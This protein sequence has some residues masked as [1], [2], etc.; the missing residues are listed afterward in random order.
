MLDSPG[1]TEI[2]PG[3][4]SFSALELTAATEWL[5][6]DSSQLTEAHALWG[7]SRWRRN[8]SCVDELNRKE[9][10]PRLK[11]RVELAG[12]NVNIIF[13]TWHIILSN[14]TWQTQ[15]YNS[16][17]IHTD[18]VT[19]WPG[20]SFTVPRCP[21]GCRSCCRWAVKSPVQTANNQFIYSWNKS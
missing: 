7:S 12:N 20:L 19:W 8:Q 1:T 18:C 5:N 11:P 16:T 3:F 15:F 9:I 4:S 10:C 17:K 6:L 21:T 2:K 13:F 14:K